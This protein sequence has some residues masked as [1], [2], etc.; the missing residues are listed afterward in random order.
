MAFV[1]KIL[2]E[3]Q[4]RDQWVLPEFNGIDAGDIALA[5]VRAMERPEA[6][7]VRFIGSNG[8]NFIRR[9]VTSY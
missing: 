9:K 6:A 5:H 4:P 3:N 8:E 7:G 2:W 1:Y